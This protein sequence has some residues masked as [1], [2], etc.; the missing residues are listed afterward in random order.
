MNTNRQIISCKLRE[1]LLCLVCAAKENFEMLLGTKWNK[2]IEL[3]D[4]TCQKRETVEGVFHN[5]LAVYWNRKVP[6][7]DGTGRLNMIFSSDIPRDLR[8]FIPSGLKIVR[9]LSK[10]Q[11][12]LSSR[13]FTAARATILKWGKLADRVSIAVGSQRSE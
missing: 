7:E 4:N 5:F 8:F 10:S 12:Q 3:Q 11:K 13:T 1:Y 6:K 9:I 2:R